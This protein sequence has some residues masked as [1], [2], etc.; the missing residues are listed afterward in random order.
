MK[1]RFL[2][3]QENKFGKKSQFDVKNKHQ[4]YHPMIL[5]CSE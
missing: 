3:V 5:W 1:I 2:N 4:H